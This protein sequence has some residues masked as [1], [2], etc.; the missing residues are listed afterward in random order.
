MCV[1]ER[2]VNAPKRVCSRLRLST[3]NQRGRATSTPAQAF[4]R[5]RQL[6]ALLLTATFCPLV[7]LWPGRRGVGYRAA[8]GPERRGCAL[9]RMWCHRGARDGI[10]H[11]PVPV[12]RAGIAPLLLDEPPSQELALSVLGG[13][14]RGARR[15]G[16]ARRL[17]TNG[18]EGHAGAP[19]SGRQPNAPMVAATS[20]GDRGGSK[21]GHARVL[22][23]EVPLG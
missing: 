12:A 10:V 8:A 18:A 4:D 9:M 19:V 6:S 7:R 14:L 3:V 21:D 15:C 1:E 23:A 13:R 2:R 20:E 11:E 22:V 17:L 16:R 5:D